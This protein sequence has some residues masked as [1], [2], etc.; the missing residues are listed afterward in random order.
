[1]AAA[2]QSVKFALLSQD[3][4]NSTDAVLSITAVNTQ[5]CPFWRAVLRVKGEKPRFGT[6]HRSA[7]ES[8]RKLLSKW[9][10]RIPAAAEERALVECGAQPRSSRRVPSLNQ[11]EG[12]R[13]VPVR[14][15]KRQL[16]HH[17]CDAVRKVAPTEKGR[18]GDLHYLIRMP[19]QPEEDLS[20]PCLCCCFYTAQESEAK[21][22][23]ASCTRCSNMALGNA[24]ELTSFAF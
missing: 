24:A 1:M 6:R 5:S 7:V 17:D 15:C 21:M 23:V 14:A 20:I 16:N 18:V 2:Q 12:Q 10:H 8:V 22:M 9:S 11:L 3:N 19:L 4:I 13:P